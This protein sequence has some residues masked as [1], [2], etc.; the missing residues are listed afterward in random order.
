MSTYG[1]T[2]NKEKKI[3]VFM[4]IV[5]THIHTHIPICECVYVYVCM[6]GERERESAHILQELVSILKKNRDE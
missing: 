5:L 1:I 2:V 6:Y 3:P 4:E